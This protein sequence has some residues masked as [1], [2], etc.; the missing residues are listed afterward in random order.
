MKVALTDYSEIQWKIMYGFD[1][2]S[3]S[4]YWLVPVILPAEVQER[5]DKEFIRKFTGDNMIKEEDIEREVMQ[6]I[7]GILNYV[8]VATPDGTYRKLRSKILR[9]G[10]NCIR[11][12]TV[13]REGSFKDSIIE[14][15]YD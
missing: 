13:A 1:D 5:L 8:Q 10:N 9:L 14:K 6:A 2:E 7:E 15:G 12:L 4:Y 11:N 3:M